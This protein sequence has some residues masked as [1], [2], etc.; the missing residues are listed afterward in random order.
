MLASRAFLVLPVLAS[1]LTLAEA[2]RRAPL[3]PRPPAARGVFEI[4]A[5]SLGCERGPDG[6]QCTEAEIH[7]NEQVRITF[8]QPVDF[9]SVSLA[10]FRVRDVTTGQAPPGTIAP[11][12]QDDRTLVY[13]PQLTFDSAG[14]P[15][16]GLVDGHTYLL[17]LPGTDQDPL[18]PYVSSLGGLPNRTR[19]RC[20]LVASLGVADAVPGRP[21]VKLFVQAVLA[22]DPVTGEPVRTALVPAQGAIDVLRSS[23]VELHFADLMNPAT[24]A[25]PVTGTSSFLR[26]FFDPDGD[27]RDVSDWIRVPGTFQLALDQTGLTTRV[28]FLADG[29]L[30]PS[31]T[32]GRAGRVVF[33]V[34]PQVADLGGNPLLNPGTTSFTTEP[35]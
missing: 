22:R 31:G 17:E 12:P 33:Q 27:L 21:Y 23:P 32:P 28:R 5:C 8:N 34:T 35:R 14:N 26:A 19:L 3:R 7:V 25:N 29:G 11:D 10:S 13:R 16:F 15:V 30:P 9:A 20:L 6:F 24:L 18:G 2:Q 4:V 1:L